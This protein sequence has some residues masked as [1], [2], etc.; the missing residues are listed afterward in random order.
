MLVTPIVWV[1]NAFSVA[2][3]VIVYYNNNAWSRRT[4]R[5]LAFLFIIFGQLCD[6]AILALLLW[7]AWSFGRKDDT[8]YVVKDSR[9]SESVRDSNVRDSVL[10]D[11]TTTTNGNGY[12]T[13]NTNGYNTTANAN[14]N[15]NGYNTANADEY[16]TTNSNGYNRDVGYVPHVTV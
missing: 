4:N 9:Y 1:R 16:T 6:L 3:I 13:A 14:A 5:A 12:N 11:G 15:A 10:A 8:P 7:G 2:Q